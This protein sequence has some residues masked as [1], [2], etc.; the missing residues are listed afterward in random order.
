MAR[1]LRRASASSPM[2]PEEPPDL[3]PFPEHFRSDGK[4]WAAAVNGKSGRHRTFRVIRNVALSLWVVFVVG[5]GVAIAYDHATASHLLPATRIGGVKVGSRSP[6]EAKALLT[7][8]VVR[9]LQTRPLTLRAHTTLHVSAWDM[10]V[11]I[12]LGDALRAVHQRQR[13]TPIVTRLW[14]R[15]FGDDTPNPLR[16]E[17]DQGRLQAFLAKTAAQVDRPVRDAT[18]EVQGDALKVVPHEVGRRLDVGAARK[19]LVG[20]LTTGVTNIR[21]PVE[22]TQP[23]LRTEQFSKVIMVHTGSQ[24]LDLYLD[25]KVGRSFPVATGTPGYPTPHGQFHIT[26]KRMNPTW[27]NPWADWSMNMPAFIGPGPNNPLGTRAMNLS[28]GGIRIHGS[29]DAASIGRPAS[30][31]CIRMHLRDAEELF[32]MIDVGT[33]VL[34]RAT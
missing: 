19:Q 6:A 22:L 16:S 30:H 31:G 28:V 33:P 25:G 32:D 20:A 12:D 3:G 1:V 8:R 4:A 2:P 13:S 11:H 14:R 26:A 10:G 17:I 15:V 29:P 23:E 27:G 21:L 7:E 24:R 9:P 18:V 34:V 5:S